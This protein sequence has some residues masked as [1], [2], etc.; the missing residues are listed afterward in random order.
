MKKRF[1]LGFY[2]LLNRDS[3]APLCRYFY[4][5]DTYLGRLRCDYIT[6]KWIKSMTP[7]NQ[8]EK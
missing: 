5:M 6:P 7:L 8:K 4:G 1:V 2:K 3:L